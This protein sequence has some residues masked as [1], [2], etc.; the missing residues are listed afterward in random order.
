MRLE[1]KTLQRV[2]H[3]PLWARRRALRE[4]WRTIGLAGRLPRVGIES[5]VRDVLRLPGA[6][7]ARLEKEI[8]Y[9]DWISIV[10]W[11]SLT[12]RSQVAIR[13]DAESISI[14]N[15]SVFERLAQSGRPVIL[16]PIHMGCFAL[17]FT[18]IMHD[19]FAGRRLLI[20]RAREDR[21]DETLAMRRISEIGI[22]MRFLNVAAKQN[23]FDAVKFAK[24]G[25]VVVMFVDL[26]ASYGGSTPVRL[27]GKPI[28][29]AMG[30]G[31]LARLTEAAVIPVSVHSSVH[32]D[33]VRV[34]APFES[35]A[36]GPEERSRIADIVRRHIE[37]AIRR[38][39]AC[40]HMWSRFGEFV[41]EGDVE[42]EAV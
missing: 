1:A 14:E 35:H 13:R 38:T 25:A 7:A 26:P 8:L 21:H 41:D 5:I 28:R 4:I 33:S 17:P 18:K 16:A 11:A 6:E 40:W 22:D 10:E 23:Y 2:A 19:Y 27:F 9:Q 24:A 3:L 31:S 30:I 12:R 37:D 36:K 29:L 32:G 34:G 42:S 39:P 20:L 15:A